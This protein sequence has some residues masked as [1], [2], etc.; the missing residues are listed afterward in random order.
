M[1]F[2]KIWRSASSPVQLALSSRIELSS[3][4]DDPTLR[5][6]SY[7]PTNGFILDKPADRKTNR[8]TLFFDRA[9]RNSK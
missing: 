5:R 9:R 3:S 8:V 7:Q 1:R 2:L 4:T 6:P